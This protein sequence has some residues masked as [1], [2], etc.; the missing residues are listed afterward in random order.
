MSVVKNNPFRYSAGAQ[1]L[2]PPTKPGSSSHAALSRR[3]RRV[4][5]PSRPALLPNSSSVLPC[6]P[7]FDCGVVFVL[8]LLL[9]LLVA[10]SSNPPNLACLAHAVCANYAAS[11]SCLCLGSLACQ[12]RKATLT[13]GSWPAG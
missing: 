11:D 12:I 8:L 5:C 4:L 1:V 7:A 3:F 9:R 6:W 2:V 10:F 13:G